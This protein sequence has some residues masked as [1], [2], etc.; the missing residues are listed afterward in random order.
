MNRVKILVLGM[1]LTF[2]AACSEPLTE[3]MEEDASLSVSVDSDE[4]VSDVCDNGEIVLGD[5]LPNPYSMENMR[6]AI[7]ELQSR[8]LSKASLSTDI[9]ATHY[10]MRFKPKNEAE[11]DAVEA[12]TTVFYYSWPLDREIVAGSTNYHDPELPDSV[13]SY[14]YCTIPV[15]HVMPD[16]EHEILEELYILEDVNVYDDPN[17]DEATSLSKHAKT[18]YWTELKNIALEM[19]G[20][21]PE[22][23]SLSKS[24]TPK[25]RIT[26]YDNTINKDIPLQ[27]VLVRTT[28][29][30]ISHQ[31]YT[32]ANGAFT[33]SSVNGKH[34]FVIKWQ[35]SNF[36]IR[37]NSDLEVA[38]L[39]IAH[40]IKK[41]TINYSIGI[42]HGLEWKIASVFR[43][44]ISYYQKAIGFSDPKWPMKISVTNIDNSDWYMYDGRGKL[45]NGRFLGDSEARV[46]ANSINKSADLYFVGNAII[47]QGWHESAS[48]DYN[49]AH[50]DFYGDQFY[51]STSNTLKRDWGFSAGSY[52]TRKQYPNFGIKGEIAQYYMKGNNAEPSKIVSILVKSKN[53]S[54]FHKNYK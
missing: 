25:G 44:V 42:G 8:G 18:S 2:A 45:S 33:M 11:V 27:G 24:W 7:A 20:M 23:V 14:M 32:D 13:P 28:K 3:A 5:K 4:S 54:D 39:V 15:D 29:F 1:V 22:T 51:R 40:H 50:I 17:D 16:V 48:W 49:G 21:E 41:K 46:F 12:D 52:L 10:Y 36:K 9:K 35:N 38:E 31:S 6:K 43:G 26:Y 19:V 47:A 37:R 34:N 30:F 53:L